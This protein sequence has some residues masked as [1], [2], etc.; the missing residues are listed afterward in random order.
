MVKKKS[1]QDLQDGL[2][3][4]EIDMKPLVKGVKAVV[5]VFVHSHEKSVRLEETEK[6][7]D[8]KCKWFWAF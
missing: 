8:K 1:K 7:H 3:D 5:G 2:F 4:V 6:E